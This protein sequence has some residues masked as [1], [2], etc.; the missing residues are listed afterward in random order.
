MTIV[1]MLERNARLFPGKTAVIS[2]GS[3]ISYEMFH[4]Q[5]NKLANALIGMGLRKGDRVGLL[6]EKTPE[7]L[8]AFLGTAAAGG[9]VFPID[10]NQ[11]VG[12]TEFMFDLTDPTFL[13][14]D[15]RF[16]DLLSH[17][18]NR[19]PGETGDE[20]RGYAVSRRQQAAGRW[21]PAPCA[22]AGRG[23]DGQTRQ[24]E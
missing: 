8:I 3:A 4:E 2:G 20:R 19:C 12:H 5:V 10:Y 11:T 15:G 9:V 13:I 22:P 24:R 14:I 1:E 21:N 23:G 17:L 18:K 7:A 16:Q 6:L